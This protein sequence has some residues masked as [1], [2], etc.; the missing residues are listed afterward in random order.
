MAHRNA[1]SLH[2]QERSLGE[3]FSEL[4]QDVSL[5][6]RKEVELA[7]VELGQ[8]LTRAAK[9]AA[10]IGTGGALLYA[11][12]LA[13]VTALVLG[14]IDL[15]V[16]AWLAALIVGLVV[17][18]LGYVLVQR[19]RQGLKHVHVKPRRAVRQVKETVEWAKEQVT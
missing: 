10:S 5:L 11:G 9:K 13:L 8:Q 1:V 14:L 6:V 7:K 19:G 15:G 17:V 3:L 2:Q 16:T 18:A 12:T 4:S